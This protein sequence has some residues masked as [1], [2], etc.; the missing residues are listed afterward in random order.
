MSPRAYAHDPSA[1]VE[2]TFLRVMRERM[3]DVP[4]LH[5]G[6]R[7][8]AVGFQRWQQHWL[9]VLVTPW[10]MNLLLVPGSARHWVAAGDQQRRFLQFPAGSFAFLDSHED[11]LGSFQTCSLFSPM[12]MFTHQL[13]AT[14][15]ARASLLGLMS[16][17]A[18]ADAPPAPSST[19]P[20]AAAAPQATPAGARSGT[21]SRRGFFRLG[22]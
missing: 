11:D 7:V 13:H 21:L 9:G 12:G 14:Q 6:L 8:E 16:A 4:I 22:A 20:P 3:H 1:A 5:P 18:D 19:R 15:T 17:P 10:C 2:H